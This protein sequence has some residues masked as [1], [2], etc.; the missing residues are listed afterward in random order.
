MNPS[1][2]EASEKEN[3]TQDRPAARGRPDARSVVRRALEE[4]TP[5]THHNVEGVVG[6]ERDDDAWKVIV[7]V[8]EDAHM[9]STSDILAEYEVRM[10]TDGELVGYG[11]GRRYVRGRVEA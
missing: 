10:S 3:Q 8:L 9:P 4:F 5:L 2:E 7:E 1:H 6:I 11:R